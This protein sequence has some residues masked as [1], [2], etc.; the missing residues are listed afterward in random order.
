MAGG[1]EKATEQLH[2]MLVCLLLGSAEV[3]DCELY[4]SS[5][6]HRCSKAA[7]IADMCGLMMHDYWRM[8]PEKGT[9]RGTVLTS[10]LGEVTNW[11]TLCLAIICLELATLLDI[12]PEAQNGTRLQCRVGAWSLHH[13]PRHAHLLH[14]RRTLKSA[15]LICAINF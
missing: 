1:R 14:A 7:H 9:G 6:L 15:G 10:P 3:G 12:N 2:T 4:L 11:D 8:Q 5:S 13:T